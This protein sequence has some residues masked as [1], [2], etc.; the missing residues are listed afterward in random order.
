MG[1]RRS[2]GEIKH[3]SV[4]HSVGGMVRELWRIVA[5]L[6]QKKEVKYKY[7]YMCTVQVSLDGKNFSHRLE[8]LSWLPEWHWSLLRIISEIL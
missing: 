5:A 2:E 4:F 8:C 6:M 7:A 3:F 1:S